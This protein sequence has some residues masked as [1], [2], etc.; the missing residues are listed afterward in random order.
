MATKRML[1][2]FAHPDD[3]SY[4]PGGTIARYALEGV[5][6]F[7]TMFTAG[8]AGS[9]GISKTLA[10]DELARRRRLELAAACAA[11]GVREHRILGVPDGGVSK[12]DR[13]WAVQEI[14]SDIRRYRPHVAMTFHRGGVSAHPDHI[15]V[16]HY[17]D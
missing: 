14:V 10:R 9:I 2:V 6:V 3:E 17:L 7:L 15:A 8:E 1:C 5:D 4:G 12:V 16:S 13:A 11:L